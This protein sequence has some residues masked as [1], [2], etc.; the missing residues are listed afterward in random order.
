MLQR[1]GGDDPVPFE[2]GHR[3]E[4][5][6]AVEPDHRLQRGQRP[7]D[8]RPGRQATGG[9]GLGRGF[10]LGIGG[11]GGPE[12]RAEERL[13]L[14]HKPRPP[15]GMALGLTLVLGLQE[16]RHQAG[17]VRAATLG[18]QGHGGLHAAA[19]RRHDALRRQ[20]IQHQ[21]RIA[22][23][24]QARGHHR[25]G[26]AWR[27]IGHTQ[28][29][30]G[31]AA[32]HRQQQ[33]VR[34]QA[35]EVTLVALT[36]IQPGQLAGIEEQRRGT[37]AIGLRC[38]PG[39]ALR[40]G[41]DAAL[42]VGRLGQRAPLRRAAGRRAGAGC[43][44]CRI[45]RN[46]LPL[47]DQRGTAGRAR[48]CLG[49]L[50]GGQHQCVGLPEA[51]IVQR[52]QPMAQ[53]ITRGRPRTGHQPLHAGT[54]RGMPQHGVE[55][56]TFEVEAGLGM[57]LA[58]R[59]AGPLHPMAGRPQVAGLRHQRLQAQ[60]GQPGQHRSRHRFHHRRPARAAAFDQRDRMAQLRQPDRTGAARRTAADDQDLSRT[61]RGV[62]RSRAH[63]RPGNGPA[64]RG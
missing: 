7:V 29:G 25:V 33:L 5:D 31:A 45:C 52:H 12:R 51:T 46:G 2:H 20:R 10:G 40:R 35:F 59:R 50:A 63:R 3:P 19:Q 13:R 56:G 32:Q 1:G 54:A 8:A 57:G 23:A 64:S 44:I 55:T 53:A 18:V 30:Q 41:L 61:S 11:Q 4:A 37:A 48:R 60:R 34:R 43:R 15:A 28:L 49:T 27:G 38:G 26:Q 36:G 24:Q 47:A 62:H 42:Q 17:I 22:N 39:P 21:R 6:A 58:P 14:C 16:G 9:R